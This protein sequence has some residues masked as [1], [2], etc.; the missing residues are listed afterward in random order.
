MKSQKLSL[1]VKLTEK[2]GSGP[3]HLIAP[4]LMVWFNFFFFFFFDINM[5]LPINTA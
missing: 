5:D 1:S 4:F 2:H 3:V